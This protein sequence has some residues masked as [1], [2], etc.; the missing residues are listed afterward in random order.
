MIA[1]TYLSD[2]ELSFLSGL[3]KADFTTWIRQVHDRNP[4]AA[5]RIRDQLVAER[6]KSQ[7][8]LRREQW[9]ARSEKL[10]AL[11]QEIGPI[12]ALGNKA[13]RLATHDSLR[14]HCEE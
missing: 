14:V 9:R 7:I 2:D 10:V 8:E 11:G 12:P 5:R 4:E 3:S 13:R 6:D 1:A